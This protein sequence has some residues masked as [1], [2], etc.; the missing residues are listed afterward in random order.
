MVHT[1]QQFTTFDQMMITSKTKEH[2]ISIYDDTDFNNSVDIKTIPYRKRDIKNFCFLFKNPNSKYPS[3]YHLTRSLIT[4]DTGVFKDCE[5][6]TRKTI[7]SYNSAQ[8]KRQW[9]HLTD[10]LSHDVVILT[11]YNNSYVV[12][13]SPSSNQGSATHSLEYS[14]FTY[15]DTKF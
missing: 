13:Y 3:S 1:K 8:A 4:C 14:Y 10:I 9:K 11:H 5:H 2:Q 6:K 7:Y 12:S 15:K